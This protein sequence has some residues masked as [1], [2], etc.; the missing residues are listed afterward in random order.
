LRILRVVTSAILFA[1]IDTIE[2]NI[3]RTVMK[4]I[5]TLILIFTLSL[6]AIT[7]SSSF[8]VFSP[9]DFLIGLSVYPNP[10]TTGDFSVKFQAVSQQEVIK[11]KVYNLIGREVH[12]EVVSPSI[13]ESKI[14]FSLRNFQKGVYMLEISQGNQRITR[15]L[16]YT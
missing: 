4:K 1:K 9:S 14:T 5:F 2:K 8:P 15:R 6:G 3:H 11:I 12:R 16:S 13:N 10:S 7:A